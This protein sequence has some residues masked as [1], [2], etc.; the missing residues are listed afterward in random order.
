M[1]SERVEIKIG[2]ERETQRERE[3]RGWRF[4]LAFDPTPCEIRFLGRG[5]HRRQA[6]FQDENLMSGGRATGGVIIIHIASSPVLN[7]ARD[8][9]SYLGCLVHQRRSSL[10]IDSTTPCIYIHKQIPFQPRPIYQHT[11]VAPHSKTIVATSCP[12]SCVIHHT[13]SPSSSDPSS[14]YPYSLEHPL[15]PL[16]IASTCPS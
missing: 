15:D 5:L 14:I 4:R 8:I 10:S 13:A 2:R 12:S 16:S 6:S 7:T 1:N 3:R 11:Y 9:I